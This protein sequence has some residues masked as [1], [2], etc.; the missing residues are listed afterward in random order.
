MQILQLILSLCV[1]QEYFVVLW[2]YRPGESFELNIFFVT[3]K[4]IFEKNSTKSFARAK[5]ENTY[6]HGNTHTHTVHI[7]AFIAR[8][9][10][11]FLFLAISSRT[12]ASLVG[13]FIAGR[14]EHS[15]VPN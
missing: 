14:V 8:G 11:F 13:Y 7:S 9:I 10:K 2:K 3:L 12:G 5:I 4:K 15:K 1:Q 6:T